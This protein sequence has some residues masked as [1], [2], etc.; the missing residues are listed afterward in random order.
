MPLPRNANCRFR[1]WQ[2]NSA[3]F[4]YSATL[5]REIVCTRLHRGPARHRMFRP[6][7]AIKRWHRWDY[8]HC[9]SC[10]Q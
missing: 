3:N 7:G 2:A 10:G 4:A 6:C 8:E 5:G 9:W 1:P